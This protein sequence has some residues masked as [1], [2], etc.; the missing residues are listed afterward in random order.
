[1]RELDL[2]GACLILSK[3]TLPIRYFFSGLW[4]TVNFFV[5][6]VIKSIL[7]FFLL[8]IQYSING[9]IYILN[10]IL[11]AIETLII[12][13]QQGIVYLGKK[14]GNF[15]VYLIKLI[16]KI[17]SYLIDGFYRVISF[18]FYPLLKLFSKQLKFLS[19]FILK[20][21][22]F[23]KE[24][25]FKLAGFLGKCISSFFIYFYNL[26]TAPFI[27]F[28][29][30]N[31][32]KLS[33]L[34]RLPKII[35]VK[36]INWYQNLLLVRNARN[37]KERKREIL[38]LD[39][40]KEDAVR[41]EYKQL[42]YYVA[43]N[44][45][46][47][48]EKRKINGYSKLEVHS[49]LVSLGYEVYKIELYKGLD[50][51][52]NKG[53][54]L[55]SGE[56][57]FFLVQLE[58]YIKAGIPLVDAVNLLSK[59]TRK[60][61]LRDLY[62]AIVYELMIGESFSEALSKQGHAFPKLLINMIK[63]AEM[64]GNLDEVLDSM[65]D[66]YTTI[67]KVK[68]QMVT[69]MMYPAVIFG[70]AII[71]IIFIMI[72]VIPE[73]ISIYE[74]LGSEVPAITLFTISLSKFLVNNYLYVIAGIIGVVVF[75]LFIYNNIKTFRFLIQWVLMHT[76]VIGKIIIYNEVTM[77]A[78]TFGSLLKHSVF[79]PETMEILSRI[80]DNEIYK[81]LI[82]E[83]VNNLSRG[84][85]ISKAFKNHWAFP[86]VAYE[87][88]LTGERTGQPGPMM[89]KVANYYQEEHSNAVSQIKVFIE[90]VMIVLLA[91]VVGF[92]LLSVVLP[93]FNIYGSF[94]LENSYEGVLE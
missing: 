83:T 87:M 14:I 86:I 80:T 71:I 13:T 61:L 72:F 42:F 57:I 39:I 50:I 5:N 26:I 59:Q 7:I 53:Y 29:N 73:F 51:G 1:M 40:S 46:G 85:L 30:V 47:K 15:L 60:A 20:I 89:E 81:M 44:T 94:D 16:I 56:L 4:L 36:I 82:Y 41:S 91:A 43:R 22:I 28:K 67:H 6:T 38:L 88:L 92:I 78:K 65:V 69:A 2:G 17:I 19:S 74:D 21:F 64:A 52:F 76:P 37:K 49:Y 8:I 62:R 90:P 75:V 31:R 3:V 34:L 25:I 93:M 32:E 18:I 84:D 54:K 33:D 27:F 35:K 45:D 58:T 77:F 12:L 23:F 70:F 79:I 66:H 24:A 68:K 55:K 9:C 11:E 10:F 48:I 63:S